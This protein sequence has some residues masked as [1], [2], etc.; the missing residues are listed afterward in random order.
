MVHEVG[1]SL[2]LTAIEGEYHNIGDND[3]WIMDSG[4]YRPFSE[5]AEIDGNGSPV[6]APFDRDYLERILPTD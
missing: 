4:N 2:G 3:G 6:W 1:H 5:R